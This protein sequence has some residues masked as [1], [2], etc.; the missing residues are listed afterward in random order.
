MFFRRLHR[1]SS[2]L[3]NSLL[4]CQ[5]LHYIPPLGAYFEAV[6]CSQCAPLAVLDGAEDSL[7]C[8][9]LSLRL[10]LRVE[11]PQAVA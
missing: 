11:A 4:T 9:I 1:S 2:L 6:S 7:K 8:A 3:P 10:E 5:A